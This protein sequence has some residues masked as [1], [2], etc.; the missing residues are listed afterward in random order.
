MIMMMIITI[1][2]IITKISGNFLPII[3]QECDTRCVAVT[4]AV[5]STIYAVSIS[6]KV[7]FTDATT[8]G[9][10]YIKVFL[11]ILQYSQERVSFLIKLQ[12]LSAATILKRDS[13]ARVFL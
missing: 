3:Q 13:N 7:R 10:L 9:V 12:A 2:I 8:G 5:L 6:D 1:I 4:L 11:K